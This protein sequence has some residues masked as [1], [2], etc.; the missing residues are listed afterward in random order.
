MDRPLAEVREER[1]EWLERCTAALTL[2]IRKLSETQQQILNL[3]YR[4]NAT[5]KDIAQE[6]DTT[7]NNIYQRLHRIR[8]QLAICVQKVVGLGDDS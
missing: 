8:R 5:A 6:F 1:S 2:C 7:E 3:F 4:G